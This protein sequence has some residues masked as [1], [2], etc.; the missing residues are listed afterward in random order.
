MMRPRFILIHFSLTNRLYFSKDIKNSLLKNS[1][2]KGV[3]KMFHQHYKNAF[4]F[5]GKHQQ[6]FLFLLQELV[7]S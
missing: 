5:A 6:E 3:K 2:M 4:A 7:H 1:L